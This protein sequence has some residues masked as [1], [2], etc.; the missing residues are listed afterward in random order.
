MTSNRKKNPRRKAP[1]GGRRKFSSYPLDFRLK[2]VKLFLEEGYSAT[3]LHEEFGIGKS[4]IHKWVKRYETN[5]EQGLIPLPKTGFGNPKIPSPVK[6][7]IVDLKRKN[8]FFGCR[9]ISD[10]LRR[11]FLM[12]ASSETVRTTLNEADLI[13]KQR[14]KPKR[15]ESKPRFFERATP[16][17][18]WQTDILT[19][20]LAGKNAYVLGYIDDYSRF[21]TGAG[22]YRSQTAEHVIETYRCAVAEYGVPKE[23]LTDNGRQYTNWRGTT[24]FEKELQKDKDY[25]QSDS[26]CQP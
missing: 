2:I 22:F 24:R 12:K 1:P 13:E 25:G 6:E 7:K 19:F 16:N 11:L 26:T 17:Q 20:R 18:M 14:K 5:G 4:T 8:P 21:I 9:K 3:V 23:M 10:I 15:N